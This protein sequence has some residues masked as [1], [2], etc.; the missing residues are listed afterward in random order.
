MGLVGR[1]DTACPRSDI[2][3]KA[4][5]RAKSGMQR[6]KPLARLTEKYF[7]RELTSRSV[8]MTDAATGNPRG[9][10]KEDFIDD[11]RVIIEAKCH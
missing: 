1:V 4:A 5:T 2:A 11:Y 3:D 6:A 10:Q 9:Q 8:V 7:Q